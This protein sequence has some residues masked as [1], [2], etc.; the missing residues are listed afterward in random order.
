MLHP[1]YVRKILWERGWGVGGGGK[2]EYWVLLGVVET[3]VRVGF[4]HCLFDLLY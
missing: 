2:R 1:G 4:I 3:I